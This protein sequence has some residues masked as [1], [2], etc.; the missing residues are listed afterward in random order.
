MDVAM[1]VYSYSNI[2]DK[3]K[4]IHEFYVIIS[5]SQTSSISA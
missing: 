5:K 4:E 3:L 2:H 1:V